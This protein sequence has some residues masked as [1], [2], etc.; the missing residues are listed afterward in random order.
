MSDPAGTEATTPLEVRLLTDD[1]STQDFFEGHAHQNIA[2]AMFALLQNEVG[3]RVIGLEGYWGS[4]KSTVI[5]LLGVTIRDHQSDHITNLSNTKRATP[6]LLV[7]DAWAHQ[8]DPLRKSFLLSLIA[9]LKEWEWI[10]EDS[11]KEFKGQLDG[12]H[13]HLNTTSTARLTPEGRVTSGALLLV[14]LGAS[15]FGTSK[16]LG[17][18]FLLAPLISVLLFWCVVRIAKFFVRIRERKQKG[19]WKLIRMFSV[20]RTFS[21]FAQNQVTD[22]ESDSTEVSEPTSVEFEEKFGQILDR[23]LSGERTLVLVLD[24]LDRIARSDARAILATMQ[25]FTGS[26]ERIRQKEWAKKVWTIVPFDS[27]GLAKLWN[28]PRTDDIDTGSNLPAGTIGRAFLDKL[29]AIRFVVPRPVLSDWRSFFLEQLRT[30]NPGIEESDLRSVVRLRALYPSIYAGGC[31]A[32]E[33]ITPRQLIQLCN[34][35]SAFRLQRNDIPLSHIAYF[36]LLERDGIDIYD[37]LTKNDEVPTW[38]VAQLGADLVSSIAALYFG[39]NP[40]HGKQ[41]LLRGPV[42]SALLAG[43]SDEI[44]RLQNDPGF[45]DTL[46]SIDLT[47]FAED[48]GV[49]LLNAAVALAGAH[50]LEHSELSDFVCWNLKPVVKGVGEWSVVDKMTGE[51]LASLCALFEGD[52]SKKEI[53]GKAKWLLSEGDDETTASLIGLASLANSLEHQNLPVSELL[54]VKCDLP[55]EL[56]VTAIATYIGVAKSVAS[57]TVLEFSCTSTELAN[58]IVRS[59]QVDP[60]SALSVYVAMRDVE[61]RVDEGQAAISIGDVLKSGD[62][63]EPTLTGLLRMLDYSRSSPEGCEAIKLNAEDG[64][65]LHHLHRA[66]TNAWPD[67]FVLAA[68]LVIEFRGP[69]LSIDPPATREAV[70]GINALRQFVSNPAGTPPIADAQLRWFAGHLN[71]ASF[72]LGKMKAQPEL[73]PWGNFFLTTIVE[74]EGETL[75]AGTF[76]NNWGVLDIALGEQ[77]FDLLA[78][79]MLTNAEK[80]NEI[81]A[82]NRDL[83]LAVRLLAT[84]SSADGD[85]ARGAVLGWAYTLISAGTKEEWLNDLQ[86]QG[87]G[88]LV[89]LVLDVSPTRKEAPV[90]PDLSD[91]LHDYAQNLESG[92]PVW[93]ISASGLKTISSLLAPANRKVLASELC[94]GLE[95]LNGSFDPAFLAVFGDFLE[96]EE[97]FRQHPKLPIVLARLVTNESWDRLKWFVD[98]AKRHSDVLNDSV[99]EEDLD[100]LKMKVQ[101]KI[102]A[103]A[104]ESS[105]SLVDLAHQLRLERG[106]G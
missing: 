86:V 44:S 92:Q 47:K 50:L 28:E 40:R 37:W 104:E 46:D 95:G 78:L 101:E 58:A 51:G 76:K 41:L 22:T 30:A 54:A 12:S 77:Q 15:L 70:Q 6:Q 88:S 61:G 53:L 94:A 29:F 52:D 66:F 45:I 69:L 106:E 17:I 4:G 97:S 93:Q 33:V 35:M 3:G 63:G 16:A 19:T 11:V 49:E 10:S 62:P 85:E 75:A 73:V 25:T 57:R 82:D 24:N 80:R 32:N 102:D 87:G 8:G 7:F 59:A 43:D 79:A 91:A 65:L 48:G 56:L 60:T 83:K 81:T 9:Q 74:K 103:D 1:P 96:D 20:A 100:D 14:P 72:V 42:E 27:A 105:D 2:N 71:V 39:T 55:A 23:S 89:H 31:V 13:V 5:T 68:M 26:S 84:T 90:S 98:M 36:I 34:Q 67:A 18:F 21:F 38:V 64:T 99:R